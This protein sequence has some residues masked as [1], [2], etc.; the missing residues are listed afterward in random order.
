MKHYSK[1]MLEGLYV[2][3]RLPIAQMALRLEC[4]PLTVMRH[5]R[6]CGIVARSASETS[7]RSCDCVEILRRYDSGES[8]SSIAKQMKIGRRR[9]ISRLKE[10]GRKIRHGA[11]YLV[12]KKRAERGL[13]WRKNISLAKVG[14]KNPNWAGGKKEENRRIRASFEFKIWREEVFGRDDWMCQKCNVR[15]GRLHPHHIENFC[16]V[17]EKRF[18][19]ENGITFCEDCHKEFHRRFGR[20]GNNSEQV[21]EFCDESH[22]HQK[23][24]AA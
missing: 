6:K 11:F 2:G 21:M 16:S 4:T 3:E 15:G 9:V 1:K 5:M 10:H 7:R 20:K 13:E 18:E 14:L 22:K 19:V 17:V 24:L 23:R 12:G 8:V